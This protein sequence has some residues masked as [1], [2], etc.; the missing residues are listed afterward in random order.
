[1]A[2]TGADVMALPERL[3]DLQALAWLGCN[4]PKTLG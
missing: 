3:A 2:I 4:S 1:M